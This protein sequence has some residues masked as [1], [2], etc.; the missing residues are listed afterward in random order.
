MVAQ[1]FGA[2]YLA[3]LYGI[4]FSSHQIGAFL[5]VWLGGRVYDVSG[6]YMP[7][8][9]LAIGLSVLAG[10]I[11]LPISDTRRPLPQPLAAT[12]PA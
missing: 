11:H 6:T 5:G 1:I 2:R 10:L 3:T 4:V 9:L 7:V 8:W 12:E